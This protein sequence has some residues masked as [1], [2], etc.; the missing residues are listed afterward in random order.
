MAPT[1]VGVCRETVAGEHRV[2]LVPDGVRALAG[3]GLRTLVESGAG[4]S[5]WLPDEDY[6]TVG[7]RIVTRDDLLGGSDVLVSVRPPNLDVGRH[8]HPGQVL[9]A[10][11]DPLGIPFQMRRW[12]DDGVTALSMDLVPG[13]WPFAH[14]MDAV[15]SQARFVGY[16]AA[17]LASD[18]Y[19]RPLPEGVC[20]GVTDPVEVLVLGA[21]TAG[22][23]AMATMRQLGAVVRGYGPTPHSRERIRSTGAA[24]L[25]VPGEP[26]PLDGA[27]QAFPG[28][29]ALRDA[30][31]ATIPRFDIVVTTVDPGVGPPPV[32]VT[33]KAIAAMRPGSVIVDT[34][35]GPAGGSVESARPGSTAVFPPGVTVIGADNLP[36]QI[37]TAASSA[38]AQNIVALLARMQQDGSTVID[39]TD[40]VQAAIVVTHDRLVLNESV[41]RY[42]LEETALAGLP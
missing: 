41:W 7:A 28:R 40:P 31:T 15:D 12:A 30:L 34:T 24:V 21:Q 27:G 10:L 25:D 17:L 29:S 16:K 14:P 39:L 33:P 23:Q 22:L 2:A 38:Y 42:I 1:T 8:L 36:A 9:I 13:K 5:A 37:P 32:L 4:A 11:L 26:S 19:A 35:V 18:Q 3:M 6:E 20:P